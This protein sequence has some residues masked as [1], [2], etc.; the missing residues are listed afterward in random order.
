MMREFA[1]LPVSLLENTMLP[2]SLQNAVA[3]LH[4]GGVIAYPTEAVW[5][6]GC[7][8]FDALAVDKILRLKQRPLEKGLIVVAADPQQIATLL[9][10]LSVEERQL[11]AASW[12]G[13][14]TWLLPDPHQYFPAWI[15]GSFD[16]VAVRVSA[17]P[18]VRKLCL[19]Y[20]GP[21]V[22]TSANPAALPPARTRLQVLRW[23]GRNLDCV[24]PGQLGGLATPS[25]IRDLRSGQLVRG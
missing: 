22:S 5:G 10:G 21:V 6:L 1:R 25:T 24:L 18:L 2:L 11:L 15:R 20:G 13:P 9:E 3:A 4:S 8:P 23:F 16:T 14:H 7:D 19:A 12:P 17:H